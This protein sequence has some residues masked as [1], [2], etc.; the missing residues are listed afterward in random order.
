[1]ATYGLKCDV[2]RID[3]DSRALRSMLDKA[4]VDGLLLKIGSEGD[5]CVMKGGVWYLDEGNGMLGDIIDEKFVRKLVDNDDEVST[6][7]II[8][9]CSVGE[10][11]CEDIFNMCFFFDLF[12]DEGDGSE[13]FPAEIVVQDG[14][15]NQRDVNN[16]VGLIQQLNLTYGEMAESK[17]EGA[18]KWARHMKKTMYRAMEEEKLWKWMKQVGEAGGDVFEFDCGARGTIDE[19][20]DYNMAMELR[21]EVFGE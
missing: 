13:F 6:F 10:V 21:H 9:G 17:L 20:E 4:D 16:L 7:D 1:M 18:F 11:D 19:S 12:D 5:E 8:V 15:V 14:D 3:T 2:Y